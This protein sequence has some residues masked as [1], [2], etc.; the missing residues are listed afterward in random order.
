MSI[1]QPIKVSDQITTG[2]GRVTEW[3]SLNNVRTLRL[4]V[5]TT[6]AMALAHAI[7][8]PLSFVTPALVVGVLTVPSP[9]VTYGETLRNILYAVF[10]FSFGLVITL[11]F[12]P[13]PIVFC[14]VSGLIFFFVHY[15]LHKG[16]PIFLSLMLVLTTTILPLVA[17]AHE[18]LSR[19]LALSILWGACLAA[20]I[21][22]LAWALF[23]DPPG[24]ETVPATGFQPDYSRHAAIIALQTTIVILLAMIAFLSFNWTAHV[25]A[26][27][28]INLIALEGG[29]AHSKKK[30]Q[31]FLLANLGGGLAATVFYCLIVAVPAYH[32]FVFLMLLTTLLFGTRAFSDRSTARYY[33]TALIG[34]VVL[35][36][37]S[38]GPGSDMS[39]V[40]FKRVLYIAMA[41]VYV[42]AA[43]LVLER[44]VFKHDGK[45]H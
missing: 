8:W 40:W 28:Y 41:A 17:N 22:Q 1:N 43:T 30:A 38:T 34:L 19:Y 12:L 2:A 27:L 10:V 37:S 36:S 20:V 44:F 5:A 32:F 25:V 14:L 23:P 3:L 11:F 9:P 7:N 45:A 13:F 18:G 39:V 29:I 4:S 16:A 35:I 26:M 31:H 42:I 6:I 24:A 21:I 15:Y 33:P